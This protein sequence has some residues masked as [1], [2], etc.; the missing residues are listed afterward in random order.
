[1][2]VYDIMLNKLTEPQMLK[3]ERHSEIVR[4][5][6]KH[7]FVQTE[8]FASMLGV[9]SVTIRRDIKELDKK[10]LIRMVYGG[11]SSIGYLQERPEPEYDTKTHICALQKSAIGKKA[12]TFINNGDI[13]IL[14]A[15]TT[16]LQIAKQI[17]IGNFTKLSVITSDIISAKELNSNPDIMVILLGG[18]MR[19]QYHCVFGTFAENLVSNMRANKYFFAFDGFTPDRGFSST[20]LEEIPLKQKMIEIS[21]T[22]I[23]VS[24]SSKIGTDALYTICNPDKVSQ[25]IT[26]SG[27]DPMYKESILSK[28]IDISIVEV[29]ENELSL[30]SR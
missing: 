5:T 8:K 20:F 27:I 23:A 1:M 26:D 14:D 11:A 22:V 24:D 2:N 9:S 28:G 25:L 16:C 17:S 21:Q 13:L 4:L 6:E 15:G 10:N 3:A 18:V 7:G 19:N 29:E 12:V 30:M